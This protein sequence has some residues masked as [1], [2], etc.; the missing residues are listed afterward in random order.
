MASAA[1]RSHAG[2]LLGMEVVVPAA[3]VATA[4]STTSSLACMARNIAGGQTERR[5][6]SWHLSSM[7]ADSDIRQPALFVSHGSPMVALDEDDYTRALAGF[8]AAR[9]QPAA[10]LVV[11]A[12]WEAPP[13]VRGTKSSPP[14]LI[15]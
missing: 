15:Y 5:D 7:P 9:S 1:S 13:P 8:T 12:H 10:I 4:A 2:Q 11:S 14:P 6:F 3:V